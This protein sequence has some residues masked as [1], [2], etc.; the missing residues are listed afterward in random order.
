MQFDNCLLIEYDSCFHF[1]RQK[2]EIGTEAYTATHFLFIFAEQANIH[3]ETLEKYI[4]EILL[5]QLESLNIK[6]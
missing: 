1:T 6:S 3:R 4:P 5:N 2:K